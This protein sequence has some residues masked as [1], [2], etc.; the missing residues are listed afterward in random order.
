MS[1]S[2]ASRTG[3]M[4]G[5]LA[6]EDHLEFGFLGHLERDLKSYSY[7]HLTAPGRFKR[8]AVALVLRVR[9]SA[10]RITGYMLVI[11]LRVY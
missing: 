10:K 8:A 2:L 6:A 11:C 3:E 7:R 5:S 4:K 1:A 9:T